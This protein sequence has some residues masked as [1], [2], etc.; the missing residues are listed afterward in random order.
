MMKGLMMIAEAMVAGARES[1]TTMKLTRL[2][3]PG[4]FAPALKRAKCRVSTLNANR[5]QAKRRL[6]MRRRYPHG[7]KKGRK[8]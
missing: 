5:S 7:W 2:P 3:D 4:E 1:T 6:D 8:P